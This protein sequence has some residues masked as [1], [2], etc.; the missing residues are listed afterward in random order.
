M[1][2]NI[3]NLFNFL[4]KNLNVITPGLLLCGSL[5]LIK[6]EFIDK[7]KNK[8]KILFD[9]NSLNFKGWETKDAYSND[10]SFTINNLITNNQIVD[11]F[12]KIPKEEDL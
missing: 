4:S 2:K 6:F 10:V 12:F 1:S 11:S 9:K 3:F 5:C 7:K 8:L